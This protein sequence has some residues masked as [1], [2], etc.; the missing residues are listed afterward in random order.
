M[1]LE[2]ENGE[3]SL[4]RIDDVD[5]QDYVTQ[6]ENGAFDIEGS[7]VLVLGDGPTRSESDRLCSVHVVDV[8]PGAEDT[9]QVGPHE[10]LHC[11]Y[12]M[13][14]SNGGV[15]HDFGIVDTENMIKAI[16]ME[17]KDDPEMTVLWMNDRDEEFTGQILS[18]IRMEFGDDRIQPDGE[19]VDDV[20]DDD[21]DDESDEWPYYN[22]LPDDMGRCSVANR[23]HTATDFYKT[24]GGELECSLCNEVI[25]R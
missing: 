9:S 19:T 3:W 4:A 17:L 24:D 2:P 12:W 10:L 5:P 11:V 25:D 21:R 15:R 18:A 14:P 23:P 20:L 13:R 22:Q 8:D 7:P 6:R 1:N 16:A